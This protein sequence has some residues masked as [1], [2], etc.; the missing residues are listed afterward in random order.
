MSV[1]EHVGVELIPLIELIVGRSDNR[2]LTWDEG[3]VPHEVS[4]P[5]AGN[6]LVLERLWQFRSRGSFRCRLA[7]RYL[8]D[9]ALHSSCST[10][11]CILEL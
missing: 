9:L 1:H 3:T 6:P 5:R 4:Q 7:A 11:L 10:L 8:L 2:R